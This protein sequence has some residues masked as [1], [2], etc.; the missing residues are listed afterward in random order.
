MKST[1]KN[2][3]TPLSA[4]QQ[5]LL[6][7]RWQK[8]RLAIFQRDDWACQKCFDRT[9]TLHVYH[10]YYNRNTE[11]WDYPDDALITFCAPC[12]AK[13]TQY[14]RVQKQQRGSLAHPCPSFDQYIL[15]LK[16]LFAVAESGSL[17]TKM[18]QKDKKFLARLFVAHATGEP[19][20]TSVQ[21][22]MVE[23][24]LLNNEHIWATSEHD[25]WFLRPSTPRKPIGSTGG[26]H[27]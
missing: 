8:K 6:D 18:S 2:S 4:Y 14:G 9:N 16:L 11:P 22:G 19:K 23:R 25:G 1:T 3:A 27:A 17:P 5:K 12:H 13:E 7:P 21:Q 10:R 20:I 26:T 15:D 24:I